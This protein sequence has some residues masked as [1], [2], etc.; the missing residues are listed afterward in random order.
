MKNEELKTEK[1]LLTR[2]PFFIFHSSFLIFHSRDPS[3]GVLASRNLY[4]EAN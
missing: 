1:G 2:V 3:A 4:E